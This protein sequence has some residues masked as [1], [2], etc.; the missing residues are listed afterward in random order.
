MENIWGEIRND[1]EDDDITMIDAWLTDDDNEEGAVIAEVNRATGE[2]TYKDDRAKTDP[3][4]Q[5][6]IRE[7]M[8]EE[9]Y[10][11]VL[12]EI[13]AGIEIGDVDAIDE[14]L[15]FVPKTNLIQFLAE[16]EWKR[17]DNVK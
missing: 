16:E 11:R 13:K 10:N 9:L 12:E 7:V 5:E 1:H 14:L 15:T 4:A 17:F 6:L 3:L 8:E 2:I